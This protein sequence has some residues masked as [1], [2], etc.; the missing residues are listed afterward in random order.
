MIS[1]TIDIAL[2][3]KGA[4]ILFLKRRPPHTCWYAAGLFWLPWLGGLGGAHGGELAAELADAQLERGDLIAL[5]G[6]QRGLLGEP[7]TERDDLAALRRLLALE[8]ADLF[9][10]PLM[11]SD[12][13]VVA[14][15]VHGLV[16][17]SLLHVSSLWLVDVWRE[18]SLAFVQCS[19]Q[20]MLAENWYFVNAKGNRR[21]PEVVCGGRLRGK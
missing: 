19:K 2:G 14:H 9:T 13:L 11:A 3:I 21:I 17:L 20:N 15:L 1:I 7:T 5:T 12:Q 4:I 8:A 16:T 18:P 6:V 10:Q